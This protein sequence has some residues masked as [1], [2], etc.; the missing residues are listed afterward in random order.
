[1]TAL[2][3]QRLTR[4]AFVGGAPGLQLNMSPGGARTWRLF[5]RLPGEKKRLAM[6]LGR[7]PDLSLADARKRG[8]EKLAQAADGQDPKKQRAE[9]VMARRVSV[10]VALDDYLSWCTT[11]NAQRTLQE[12][13]I[14]LR[15][16]LKSVATCALVD[17]SR[18]DVHRILDEMNDRPGA[19]RTCYLYLSHFMNW[20]VEREL[21]DSNP[22]DGVTAPK[23]V[24][25][26]DR[27]LTADEI[28]ALWQASGTMALIAR[29]CL[30]TAQRRGSVEAMR[31]VDIDFDR[32]VW[33]I[34]ASNMK[35]GKL[36]EVP[37]SE[38]AIA[39]IQRMQRLNG[40]FIFG[41]GSNGARPY[42]G[43]SNGM[44]GLRRQLGQPD[45]R[46]HDLRRTAVTLAQRG[47]AAIEEIRALTQHKTPGV[48][49][50]YARHAY[51]EEKRKVVEI[52]NDKVSDIVN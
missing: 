18:K 9:T 28:K 40:P 4:S 50:V 23:P 49:G 5:Y 36:H 11:R 7:Y 30:L 21:I 31:W 35:S 6:S 25:A 34:P 37:L 12:K 48:I 41:V 10:L 29:I 16:H 46:I 13:R 52:I 43:A 1:M 44:E 39:E 33:T 19:K 22:V 17:F 45:W 26:R 38:L 27:I 8:Q 14:M 32:L 15:F 42:A 47:G 51:A 3:V 24:K 20:C 2:E